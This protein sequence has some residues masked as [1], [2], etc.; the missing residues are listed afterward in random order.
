MATTKTTTITTTTTTV[1]TTATTTTT[2]MATTTATTMTTTTW[3]AVGEMVV[4]MRWEEGK[5]H[6]IGNLQNLNEFNFM[7]YI[8]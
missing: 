6:K 5:S 2:K 4:G 3:A 8:V 1:T 7:G